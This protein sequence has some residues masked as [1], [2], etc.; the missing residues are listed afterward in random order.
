MTKLLK[1]NITA[2]L[3]TL[4]V[5][6]V[7]ADE[8]QDLMDLVTE[9]NYVIS[10]A[11]QMKA[12]NSSNRGRLKFNYN[13]FINQLKQTRQNTLLYLNS[14]GEHINNKAP[15]HIDDELRIYK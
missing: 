7:Q 13:A 10:K 2:I 1:L 14:K 4:S 8:R 15:L 6:V 5:N 11:E 9:I 12:R 3:I